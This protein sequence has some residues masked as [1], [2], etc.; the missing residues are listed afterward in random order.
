M[1]A[2]AESAFDRAI[3][4]GEADLVK[5]ECPNCHGIELYLRKV[6]TVTCPYCGNIWEWKALRLVRLGGKG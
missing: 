5:V 1:H 6:E 3:R 4:G 2:R